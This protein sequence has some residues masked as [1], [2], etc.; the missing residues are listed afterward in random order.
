MTVYWV[1]PYLGATTQGNG[2]TDT[3][4]RSGTYAAPFGL[5]DC[6][7]D[8]T[9]E[10]NFLQGTTL[11]DG[12]EIR[13]KGLS[14]STLFNLGCTNGYASSSSLRIN[15]NQITLAEWNATNI[16]ALEPT[17]MADFLGPCDDNYIFYPAS[18]STVNDAQNFAG[19]FIPQ[20]SYGLSRKYGSPNNTST[21]FNIYAMDSDY[22]NPI[23]GF[24]SH[25]YFLPHVSSTK[26]ITLSAGWDSSTTQDG[27]SL[28]IYQPA[29]TYKSLYFFGLNNKQSP[30]VCDL[31]KFSVM[32]QDSS[33]GRDYNAYVNY[34]SG[35]SSNGGTNLNTTDYL[36][37]V[38]GCYITYHGQ[39]TQNN[40]YQWPDRILDKSV[41]DY[42]RYYPI[43]NSTSS[44]LQANFVVVDYTN[45]SIHGSS[46]IASSYEGTTIGL[47]TLFVWIYNTDEPTIFNG[48]DLRSVKGLELLSDSVY[49]MASVGSFG[50]ISASL[51]DHYGTSFTNTYG[52]NIYDWNDASGPVYHS[53]STKLIGPTIGGLQIYGFDSDVAPT[54]KFDP[55]LAFD[56]TISAT[57]Q[58]FPCGKLSCSGTDYRNTNPTLKM[59]SMSNHSQ[60]NAT[61][62][63]SIIPAFP[64]FIFETNDYDNRPIALIPPDESSASSL[65][66][67]CALLYNDTANSDILTFQPGAG[68]SSGRS[69]QAAFPLV[70]PSYTVG[71]DNLKVDL[72]VTRASTSAF[73]GDSTAKIWLGLLYYD[74][75]QSVNYRAEATTETALSSLSTTTS[76]PTT[77][78]LTL[79][80]LPTTG[81]Q[82]SSALAVLDVYFGD[83]ADYAD[84]L[85]IHDLTISAV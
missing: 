15:N 14:F 47:G 1:D 21:S 34:T 48:S 11:A 37:S 27:I 18:L 55:V 3:T 8:N 45:D 24:S 41:A 79:S 22:Y 63:S 44:K 60:G 32:T 80:N 25:G 5:D 29:S 19:S 7:K 58:N 68:T 72:K 77:I 10:S 54:G 84:K 50:Y 31:R 17:K 61:T 57:I 83:S 12:D 6:V 76:S 66:Y 30:F 33:T 65:N 39:S 56:S 62:D 67:S 85:L 46:S 64:K 51:T 75:S 4:S 16:I 42:I 78:T 81:A 26:S 28:F 23:S 70:P 38:F 74:P 53:R 73:S 71:S 43:S 82:L 69:H 36:G 35:R 13:I 52:S 40:T 59:L 2:T 9:T 49:Y 20:L